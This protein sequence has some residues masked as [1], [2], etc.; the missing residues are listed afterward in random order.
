MEKDGQW[1]DHVVI[2]AMARMLRHDIKILQSTPSSDDIK[3]R[4]SL[5]KGSEQPSINPLILGHIF[6]LHYVSLHKKGPNS[7]EEIDDG[8][9]N[10]NKS[11]NQPDDISKFLTITKSTVTIKPSENDSMEMVRDI[12][13]KNLIF[14]KHNETSD[15]NSYK[16]KDRTVSVLWHKTDKLVVYGKEEDRSR[17]SMSLVSSLKQLE[18]NQERNSEECLLTDEVKEIDSEERLHTDKSKES[19]SEERLCRHCSEHNLEIRGNPRKD[20][21]CFFAA[22]SSQIEI[23]NL[24][25]HFKLDRIDPQYLRQRVT[26]FIRNNRTIQGTDIEITDFVG[27]IDEYCDGMEKDG[28]WADHVAVVAMARMLRHDIK[29]LLSTPSSDDIKDRFSLIKGSEQPSGE[30]LVLGHIFECHYVSLHKKDEFS[31]NQE[32]KPTHKLNEMSSTTKTSKEQIKMKGNRKAEFFEKDTPH[33]FIKRY[34]YMKFLEQFIAETQDAGLVRHVYDVFAGEGSRYSNDWSPVNSNEGSSTNKE[35]YGSPV[36]AL[37]VAIEYFVSVKQLS[38][39]YNPCVLSV[40][41]LKRTCYSELRHYSIRFCFVENG[42]KYFETLVNNI[43]LTLI[44]YNIDINIKEVKKRKNRI[45]ELEISSQNEDFP[46]FVCIKNDKFEKLDPPDLKEGEC[47]ITFI[48]P[49]GYSQIP[50]KTVEKFIGPRKSVF[51]NFMSSFVYR[52]RKTVVGLSHVTRLFDLS[53]ELFDEQI[54]EGKNLNEIYTERLKHKAKTKF[55]LNFEVI[56][57]FNQVLYYLIFVT[58]DYSNLKWM[59]KSFVFGSQFDDKLVFS[60]FLLQRRDR[61]MSLREDQDDHKAASVIFE[62]FCSQAKVQVEEIEKFIWCKTIFVWRQTLVEL[63]QRSRRLLKVEDST[64][65][66]INCSE[67]PHGALLSFR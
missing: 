18:N 3:D 29:I 5:I 38:N 39:V 47:M 40:D 58:N 14:V 37:R 56:D 66:S 50:M 67:F 24:Q 49:Y 11:L 54:N 10:N 27:D 30:P 7:N 15:T 19:D 1:A 45:M 43:K 60:D 28:Q 41:N 4:F 23:L 22:V 16:S 55:A 9:A 61:V 33:G 64:G 25:H 57:K 8:N 42:K 21:N 13:K 36:I 44:F 12:I 53:K 52:F 17:L 63:I 31:I 46:I 2:D 6:E 35:M 20:G 26:D 65:N 62:H 32:P 51:I 48:D 59:K 34:M